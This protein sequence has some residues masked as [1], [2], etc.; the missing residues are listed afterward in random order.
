[1]QQQES[2]WLALYQ[3]IN[4]AWI[5][6]LEVSSLILLLVFQSVYFIECCFLPHYFNIF[7]RTQK[8]PFEYKIL[9]FSSRQQME[10]AYKIA[11]MEFKVAVEF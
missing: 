3:K 9:E 1:M 11:K 8:S 7:S 10:E 4:A 5:V 6:Y 2:F